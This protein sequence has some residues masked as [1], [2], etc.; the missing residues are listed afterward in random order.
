MTRYLFGKDVSYN[1]VHRYIII[2]FA[3]YYLFNA[4]IRFLSLSYSEF[5]FLSL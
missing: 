2:K 5:L 4:S 1:T 3:Y